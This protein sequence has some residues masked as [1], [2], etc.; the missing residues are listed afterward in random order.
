MS[1][2]EV[3]LVII[4]FIPAAAI[5]ICSYV[6]ADRLVDQMEDLESIV[7]EQEIEIKSLAFDNEEWRRKGRMKWRKTE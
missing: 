6:R 1:A 7:R 5:A 4:C 2:E 3:S